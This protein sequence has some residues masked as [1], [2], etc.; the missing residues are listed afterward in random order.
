[1]NGCDSGD[2]GEE[3]MNLM[4]RYVSWV[5]V[6]GRDKGRYWPGPQKLCTNTSTSSTIK[7]VQTAFSGD[8][9]FC[10]ILTRKFACG[11]LSNITT[12]K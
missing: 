11:I 4:D 9:T 5:R 6:C 1:V 2:D 3:K 8:K 7:F 10:N 12:P